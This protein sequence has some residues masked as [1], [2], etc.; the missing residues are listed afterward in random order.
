MMG[1]G[2]GGIK[3]ILSRA[4]HKPAVTQVKNIWPAE[5]KSFGWKSKKFDKILINL[6]KF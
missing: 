5:T 3:A 4:I 2:D 1:E 6:T